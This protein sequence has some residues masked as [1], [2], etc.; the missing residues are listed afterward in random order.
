MYATQFNFCSTL[1][2]VYPEPCLPLPQQPQDE[3]IDDKIWRAIQQGEYA[4]W[5]KK[6]EEIKQLVEFRQCTNTAF[7]WKMWSLC[8]LV[9]PGIAEAQVIWGGI[10]KCLLIAYITGNIS[11]KNIK[12]F[13]SAHVYCGKMA[14]RIKMALNGPW[15]RPHCIRRGPSFRERGRA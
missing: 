11:A 6:I 12:V 3:C 4:S 2:F 7:E 15:S 5:V 1:D 8:F 14:W 13:F 10:I 9:L